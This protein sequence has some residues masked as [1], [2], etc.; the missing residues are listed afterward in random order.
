MDYVFPVSYSIGA[1]SIS[2]VVPDK[3]GESAT[4]AKGSTLSGKITGSDLEGASPSITS[5]SAP[6]AKKTGP[7][8][9]AKTAAKTEAKTDPSQYLGTNKVAIDK[10]KTSD[11]SNLY[12]TVT[13]AD[14]VPP[15][16]EI[17][18]SVSK[19]TTSGAEKPQTA[20]YV[21]TV[22]YK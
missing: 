21:Y 8:T 17:T 16:Y 15:G 20:T 4:W 6:K 14:K 10:T 2:D 18:F 12:F 1:P 11:G 7:K 9:E 13:L 19:D 5:I 22:T 3:P